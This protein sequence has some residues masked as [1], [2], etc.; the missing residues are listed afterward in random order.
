M[1]PI[2]FNT[3]MVRAILSGSKTVTRHSAFLNNLEIL[4]DAFTPGTTNLLNPLLLERMMGFPAQ[5]TETDASET[6]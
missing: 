2:L 6:P 1:R 5:W 3:D 4:A